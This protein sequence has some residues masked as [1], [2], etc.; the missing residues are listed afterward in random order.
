MPTVGTLV[1]EA[2]WWSPNRAQHVWF[3]PVGSET[4]HPVPYAAQEKV[5]YAKSP[6]QALA[7]I[8]A[9]QN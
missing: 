2:W 9:E 1:F 4:A 7:V 8:R 5:L 3:V 6:E